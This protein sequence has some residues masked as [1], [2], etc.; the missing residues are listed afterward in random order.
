VLPESIT[1]FSAAN[2]TLS[3]Q[4]PIADASLRAMIKSV[5]GSFGS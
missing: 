5:M 4:R 3:R 2:G 1:S